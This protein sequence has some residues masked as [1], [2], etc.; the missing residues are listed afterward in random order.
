MVQGHLLFTDV[1]CLARQIVIIMVEEVVIA[2]V[3]EH[4]NT[5]LRAEIT[6]RNNMKTCILPRK[7]SFLW[8]LDTLC[9]SAKHTPTTQNKMETCIPLR[10]GS[11]FVLLTPRV[12]AQA[13]AQHDMKTCIPLEGVQLFC[14]LDTF[15]E[16]V[17]WRC[18]HVNNLIPDLREFVEN[19]RHPNVFGMAA[20]N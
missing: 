17:F 14:N 10:Q 16:Q 20:K 8:I 18:Q 1:V 2:L 11:L 9:V 15:R 13:T 12:G 6:T 4:L 5:S 19:S 3:S 7:K